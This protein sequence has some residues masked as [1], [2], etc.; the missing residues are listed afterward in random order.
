MACTVNQPVTHLTS[1][2]G[3]LEFVTNLMFRAT[4]FEY[5]QFNI[6]HA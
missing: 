1:I 3:I 2:L 6:S 4:A 5:L